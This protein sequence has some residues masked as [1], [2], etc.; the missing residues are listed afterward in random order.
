[1]EYEPI[2]E[3]DH[4]PAGLSTDQASL[5]KPFGSFNAPLLVLSS[6][7][8]LDKKSSVHLKYATTNDL[9]NQCMLTLYMKLGFHKLGIRNSA[10]LHADVFPRRLDR[11]LMPGTRGGNAVLRR[12]PNLLLKHWE[13][14]TFEC[15][16]RSSALI[17]I[18]FGLTAT[19]AYTKYLVQHDIKHEM[20]WLHGYQRHADPLNTTTMNRLVHKNPKVL[21]KKA[22]IYALRNRVNWKRSRAVEYWKQGEVKQEYGPYTRTY[23][24][25]AEQFVESKEMSRAATKRR[26]SQLSDEQREQYLCRSTGVLIKGVWLDQQ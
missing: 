18:V 9:S 7:P 22:A 8:T 5:V 24:I 10:M 26:M 25:M 6:Y 15:I 3:L 12:V 19:K 13:D 16:S 23:Q 14:F 2:H 1:M 4:I 20:V 21:P 17:C 11:N